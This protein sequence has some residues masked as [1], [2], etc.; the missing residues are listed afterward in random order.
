[1]KETV[2]KIFAIVFCFCI[3]LGLLI[4]IITMAEDLGKDAENFEKGYIQACKDFHSGKLKYDLVKEPG[5]E[6]RW[7]KI[8]NHSNH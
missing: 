8:E 6:V 7:K 3:A 4:T 1:M 2:L 5:G